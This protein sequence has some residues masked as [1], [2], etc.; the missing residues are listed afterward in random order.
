MVRAANS[1][2]SALVDA[3]GEVVASLGLF[4]SGVVAG[5]IF[6]HKGETVYAKTGEI[7]A[8]SCTIITFLILCI[9]LRGGN[10]IRTS[11]RK[12]RRA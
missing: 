2:I 4:R 1:G 8:I 6:P 7:F 5:E 3:R 10:G 9:L 12:I 11:G